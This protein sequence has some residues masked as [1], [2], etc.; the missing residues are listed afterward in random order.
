MKNYLIGL[1]F[2][3]VFQGY[4]QR[5]SITYYDHNWQL[6][7]KSLSQYCRVG[8]IDTVSYRY[9]G[10]V[11]DY[12]VKT[13]KL[14]MT[15]NYTS[16]IKNGRFRFFY[17]N[18]DQKTEGFYKDN[19]RVGIWSNYFENGRF[20]DKI[21]FNNV[22][23]DALSDYDSNG[24]QHMAQG[25]GDWQTNFF[26]SNSNQYFTIKGYYQDSL[27]EG[28]WNFYTNVMHTGL[29]GGPILQLSVKYHKG[30]F[31]TGRMFEHGKVLEMLHPPDEII[32]EN[33]KFFNIEQWRFSNYASSNEYP[34][35]RFLPKIDSTVFPVDSIAEFPGGYD[36]AATAIQR[37]I[38]LPKSYI[39]SNE[40]SGY[41]ISFII[42]EEGKLK[43]IEDHHSD[44]IL[45]KQAIKVLTNLP[46]WKP[47]MRNNKNVATHFMVHVF[48]K[49][50]HVV[51]GLVAMNDLKSYVYPL[52]Y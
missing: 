30:K 43:I 13:G 34:Y 35:L 4:T 45:Y 8:F 21:Q 18:G 10:D 37:G 25:T 27:R 28:T 39:N 23:I 48:L 19:A 50:E 49:N 47:A 6:T 31:V 42:D 26:D 17:P 33:I 7:T 11:S 16:N 14:Q 3:I 36:S 12:Y 51:V 2:S 40:D 9:Y 5:L 1:L 46:A 38:K 22:F 29:P 44:D 20:K 15:G 24:V 52:L 41:Y 32:P